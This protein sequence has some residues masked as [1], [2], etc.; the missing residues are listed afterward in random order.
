MKKM[1]N[2]RIKINHIKIKILLIRYRT[3]FNNKA[4]TIQ[5]FLFQSKKLIL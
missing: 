3:F 2:I 5:L 4:Q 1:I